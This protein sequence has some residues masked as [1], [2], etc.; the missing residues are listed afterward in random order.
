MNQILTIIQLIVGVLFVIAVL[1]QNR[2]S[3]MGAIFGGQGSVYHTKRGGEKILFW[4]TIVLAT[5]F[6]GLSL[7]STILAV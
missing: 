2:G 1:M 3:S 4:L 7:A 6:L 5:T